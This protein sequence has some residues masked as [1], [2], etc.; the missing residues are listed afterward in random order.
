MS[1]MS[2]KYFGKARD[3]LWYDDRVQFADT[4][5]YIWELL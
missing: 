1:P 2:S 4:P 5:D 3:W